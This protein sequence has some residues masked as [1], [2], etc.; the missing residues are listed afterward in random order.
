MDWL[1][2][3]SGAS[4]ALAIQLLNLMELSNIAKDKRPDLRDPLYWIP[5]AIAP[6]LGGFVAWA[7]A[8]SG[9]TVKPL[10][11]IHLGVSAPLILRAMA[12]AAPTM[13]EP[14]KPADGA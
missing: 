10:L 11:A 2:I 12:S 4:G 14:V 8:T 9:Y 6:V 3:G 13:H 7:Y 1:P 5:F